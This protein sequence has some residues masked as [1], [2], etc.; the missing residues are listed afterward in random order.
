[1]T[2]NLVKESSAAIDFSI[3]NDTEKNKYA[4]CTDDTES[5][6]EAG[7]LIPIGQIDACFIVAQGP[8]G[9]MYIIDQHAAH[10]RILYDKFARQTDGIAVQPLLVHLFLDVSPSESDLIEEHQQTLYELGF[11]AEL[12]GQNQIRL[13]DIPADI[14]SNEAE[15]VFREILHSLAQL[16]APTPQE[17]RRIESVGQW[18]FL[19]VQCEVVADTSR[20]GIF[21]DDRLVAI[22]TGTPRLGIDMADAGEGWAHAHGDTVTLRLPVVKLLDGDFIDETRTRV[23]FERGTWPNAARARLYEKARRK[24][25]R[26]CLTPSNLRRAEENARN[27]FAS[28]FTALGFQT[29][30]IAFE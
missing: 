5:I 29:V 23:F 9:G 4:N 27:Q 15:T 20:R 14:K 1:M 13:K 18:E 26:Q 19:S 7:N 10:E 3:K 11:N 17:I 8:N 6:Q 22:Y 30:E 24:M 2:K 16:H 28:L 25:L 21:S 12:A